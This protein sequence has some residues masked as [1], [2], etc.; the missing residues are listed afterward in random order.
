MLRFF[1]SFLAS[2]TAET[3]L[4]KYW[5][6]FPQSN[7]GENANDFILRVAGRA[8]YFVGP[9][10]MFSYEYVPFPSSSS[11]FLYFS[12]FSF[13]LFPF[14]SFFFVDMFKDVS[15]QNQIL[16]LQL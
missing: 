5:R 2:D 3:L 10:L 12:F 9:H 13:P 16:N 7:Q 15:L 8:E 11:V 6:L 1:N 4:N 14:S